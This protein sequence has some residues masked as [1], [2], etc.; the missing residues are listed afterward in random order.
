MKFS[1]VT[2]RL[3]VLTA[4][5]ALGGPI[6]HADIAR[7]MVVPY[8]SGLAE[9]HGAS[10]V[11]EIVKDGL[12]AT[13]IP[14]EKMRAVELMQHQLI[15]VV[16]GFGKGSL[17][18]D[19]R[20]FLDRIGLPSDLTFDE[21]T[22]YLNDP[23]HPV[24]R[25]LSDVGP[26]LSIS[27]TQLVNEHQVYTVLDAVR[28]LR[29]RS[30]LSKRKRAPELR[31]AIE[32]FLGQ[33]LDAYQV[34]EDGH[35][36]GSLPKTPGRG[37]RRASPDI[38]EPTALMD[39]PIVEVIGQG[40]N[41]APKRAARVMDDLKALREEPG[42]P[43]PLE[44]PARYYMTAH[45]YREYQS[46]GQNRRR[47]FRAT[48]ASVGLPINLSKQELEA[49]ER[50]PKD[51]LFTIL[52]PKAGID[53]VNRDIHELS[54]VIDVV[55]AL[56]SPESHWIQ[57]S[58]NAESTRREFE[59]FLGRSLTDY[60]LVAEPPLPSGALIKAEK[61]A[62]QVAPADDPADCQAILRTV[63]DEDLVAE[64]QRRLAVRSMR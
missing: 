3:M 40:F 54:S 53:L 46:R 45:F 19:I 5:L 49:F 60:A 48:M 28:Q 31:T 18:R 6:V 11:Y 61:V 59:A 32:A 39:L 13:F 62:D 56:T 22:L 16:E 25:P 9:E 24:F 21:L 4:M 57:Q 23:S 35:L 1:P 12:A 17:A 47:D 51:P 14:V 15:S 38:S 55:K 42:Q 33:S 20:S 43:S 63:S 29:G 10:H 34:D 27:W 36:T 8:I 41:F 37:K 44:T 2:S 26:R 52:S 30:R 64:L 50:N 58:I 7:E